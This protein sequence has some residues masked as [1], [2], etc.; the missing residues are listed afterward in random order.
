MKETKFLDASIWKFLLVGV[1]NTLLSMVL[2]FALEGLGYW[3]STAIAYVAGAVMSFFLNR[4]FTFRSQ[5]TMGRSAVKFA[6]NVAVCYLVAYGIAQPVMELLPQPVFVPAIWWERLTK[7]V[8]MGLY[9][10][11]NYFGQRFFAFQKQK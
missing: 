5:E 7:L 11:L 1:G 8:G 4:S 6:L 10:V 2:M 3:P 9:T